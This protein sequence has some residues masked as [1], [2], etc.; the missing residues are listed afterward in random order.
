MDPCALFDRDTKHRS[1]CWRWTA[2]C[3]KIRPAGNGRAPDHVPH[4]S[5]CTYVLFNNSKHSSLL[6]RPCLF[7]SRSQASKQLQARES[8]PK[9]SDPG[10]AIIHAQSLISPKQPL[11]ARTLLLLIVTPHPPPVIP[12]FSTPHSHDRLLNDASSLQS[13]DACMHAH[14]Q[15]TYASMHPKKQQ[16]E[17]LCPSVERHMTFKKIPTYNTRAR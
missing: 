15:C 8:T 14:L 10:G 13:S 11:H 12:V 16:N 6:L 7:P 4:L 2:H 1:N 9:P 5:D 3:L 17:N